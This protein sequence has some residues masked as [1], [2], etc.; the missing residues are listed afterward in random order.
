MVI[1]PPINQCFQHGHNVFGFEELR[2]DIGAEPHSLNTAAIF[3]LIKCQRPNQLGYGRSNRLCQRA[4]APMVYDRKAL[5]Q[6]MFKINITYM[7]TIWR[8]NKVSSL[9][10]TTHKKTGNI[11]FVANL[12]A[13]CK[14]S[15]CIKNTGT[16]SEEDWLAIMKNKIINS[17]PGGIIYLVK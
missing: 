13:F 16:G 14:K 7:D 12:L 11:Q 4:Y 15:L 5:G 6:H 9:F 10:A 17:F 2:Q 3:R 8:S 1:M